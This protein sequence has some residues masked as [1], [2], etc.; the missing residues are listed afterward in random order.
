LSLTPDE[1]FEATVSAMSTEEGVDLSKY[2]SGSG[3]K[4]RRSE[5]A[6]MAAEALQHGGGGEVESLRES[7]SSA[8]SGQESWSKGRLS[9]IDVGSLMRDVSE[10][11]VTKASD[12]D[13]KER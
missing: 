7:F 10:E 11:E 5:I 9:K 8:S 1:L 12:G 13:G 4:R 6:K 3:A 2:A